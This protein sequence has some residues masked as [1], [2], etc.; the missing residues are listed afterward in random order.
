ML[1]R[2]SPP[3]KFATASRWTAILTE[4]QSTRGPKSAAFTDT[5]GQVREFVSHF[6]DMRLV[7]G[8]NIVVAGMR[9]P[10]AV[11]AEVVR[12]A[13]A[14]GTSVNQSVAIAAATIRGCG[15]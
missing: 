8:T 15:A 7:L 2:P 12:R 1:F 14:D 11:K 5:Y 6:G 13:K 9:S 4:L 3:Q 10:T